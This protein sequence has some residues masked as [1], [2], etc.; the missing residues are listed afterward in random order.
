MKLFCYRKCASKWRKLGCLLSFR[1]TEWY[2][3]CD[4]TYKQVKV[5]PRRGT[6]D[7]HFLVGGVGQV[8]P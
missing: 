1:V 6:Q 7:P 3:L 4:G 5:G 2:L 8:W